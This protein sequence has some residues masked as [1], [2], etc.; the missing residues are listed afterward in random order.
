MNSIQYI[1]NYICSLN[2]IQHSYNQ[3]SEFV[4][5]CVTSLSFGFS[6]CVPSIDSL[7]RNLINLP[8]ITDVCSSTDK[9]ATTI[10]QRVYKC[11]LG[12]VAVT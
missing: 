9:G 8:E 10:G 2:T 12:L 1:Q 11:S 5:C 3:N 7:D 6:F 4:G